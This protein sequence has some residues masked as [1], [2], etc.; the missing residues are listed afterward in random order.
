MESELIMIV[1]DEV[2]I[3][4]VLDATLSRFGFRTM[5]AASGEEALSLARVTTFDAVLLD[6]NMPCMDGFETC[7]IMRGRDPVVPILMLSVRDTVDDKV[8][9]LDL[10]ANDYVTKPFQLRELMARL[11]AA[12]RGTKAFDS[13]QS[14]LASVL[15]VGEIELDPVRR[16]AK[17]ADQLVHL[18]PT[19]FKLT[20]H[21]MTFAGRPVSYSQLL[22]SVWGDEHEEELVY[23]R[24][25]MHQLRKKLEDDPAN[26]KY[27]LTDFSVGY[28]FVERV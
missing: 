3:R 25:F 19:E 10:G 1:D 18:T 24:T 9:A 20:Y 21:L 17:K 26:P 27:L 23:L 14:E 22:K 16:T 11:R 5:Q 2:S 28:R 13:Q 12:M 8:Q 15:R 4:Q 7:R 6:I